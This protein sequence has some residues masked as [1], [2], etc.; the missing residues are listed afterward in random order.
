MTSSASLVISA[1]CQS[2]VY[3]ESPPD[4]V[5]SGSCSGYLVVSGFH[6]ITS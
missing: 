5:P 4:P 1:M 2:T 3:V 6:N